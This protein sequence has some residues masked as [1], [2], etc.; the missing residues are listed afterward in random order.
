MT[1][2]TR[3]LKIAALAL[4][5]AGGFAASQSFGAAAAP[6]HYNSLISL[7]ETKGKVAYSQKDWIFLD[8]EHG[9]PYNPQHVAEELAEVGKHRRPDGSIAITPMVRIPMEGSGDPCWM[10]KQILDQG[11]YGIVFPRIESRTQAERAI[12]CMRYPQQ[13]ADTGRPLKPEGMRGWGPSGISKTWGMPMDQYPKRADVWPL[14]P[15]GE[16]IAMLQIE[17]ANGFKNLEEILTTPG[18]GAILVGPFDLGISLGNGFG[19]TPET[20]VVLAS[21]AKACTTHNIPCFI[22]AS[23]DADVKLRVDQGYRGILRG[24]GR[25]DSYEFR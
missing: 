10:V 11:G 2:R 18:L 25:P 8:Y 21:I 20:N 13:K 22:P 19:I 4:I 9:N 6:K 24:S 16:L 1:V 15:N 23:T 14:N 12:G 3:A 5:A 17:S 7:F